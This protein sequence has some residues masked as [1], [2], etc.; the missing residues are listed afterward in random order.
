M[1]KT[2]TY[3]LVRLRVDKEIYNF[4]P[5]PDLNQALSFLVNHT[6]KIASSLKTKNLYNYKAEVPSINLVKIHGSLNWKKSEDEEN[7]IQKLPSFG[8]EDDSSSDEKKKKFNDRFYLVIPQK[9]KFKETL[10]NRTYYDLLRMYSNEL[11]KEN[12]LLIAFGFSFEDEHIRDITIRALKNPTLQILIFAYSQADIASYSSK[13]EAYRN[14]SIIP[15]QEETPCTFDVFNNHL[16][17]IIKT[18]EESKSDKK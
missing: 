5:Y 9:G 11:D 3:H 8:S 17:K 6:P 1:E 18:T 4:G 13:F 14:V 2:G 16:E 15:P 7:I 12:T 10:L